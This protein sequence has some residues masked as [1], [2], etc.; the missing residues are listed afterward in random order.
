MDDLI[1][2]E[3]ME[4]TNAK[5]MAI[6]DINDFPKED[7]S[8]PLADLMSLGTVFSTITSAFGNVVG[9]TSG[10]VYYEAIFPITGTLA[11]KDGLSL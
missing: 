10:K 2:K 7:V 6:C 11:K 3:F 8:F 1:K 5:S 4:I 9:S